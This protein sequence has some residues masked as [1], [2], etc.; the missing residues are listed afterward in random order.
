MELHNTQNKTFSPKRIL[1]FLPFSHPKGDF[2]AK[3]K[4][5]AVHTAHCNSTHT[6]TPN[7]LR[8]EIQEVG[9]KTESPF[10][11]YIL[12]IQENGRFRIEYDVR[13]R[14]ANGE[15]F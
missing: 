13:K 1:L 9:H 2:Q 7:I 10:S 14:K 5:V 4:K 12:W 8:R 15:S 3:G 6:E 11:S